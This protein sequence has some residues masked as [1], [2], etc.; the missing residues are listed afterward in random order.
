[1]SEK[2]V[3][4]ESTPHSSSV[5][6][7]YDEKYFAWQREVGEFGGK[8]NSFKYLKTVKPTDVVIDFG[9]GGGFLLKNLECARRIG[10]EPNASASG[11]IAANG[12]EHFLSP[13]AAIEAL[14][15]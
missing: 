8:A 12:V 9:C 14:G 10:L 1:M 13:R 5:S 7:H 11:Q 3:Q 15:E 6:G 4:V 2:A